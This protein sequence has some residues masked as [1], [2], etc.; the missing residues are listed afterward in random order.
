MGIALTPDDGGYYMAGS[1]GMVYG[2][3]DAQAGGEPTGVSANLP[4]AA[5]A[6]T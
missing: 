6:G 4:V 2:F 5:I 3:G 1:D